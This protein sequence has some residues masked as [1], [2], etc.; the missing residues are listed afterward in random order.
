SRMSIWQFSLQVSRRLLVWA[1]LSIGAGALLAAQKSP[2]LQ[3]V[4]L[5]F[6][7]WGAIDG[8]IG[9]LGARG[10]R[11]RQQA[12]DAHAPQTQTAEARKLRRLLWINTAL[13]VG[14]V[15]GGLQLVRRKGDDDTWRGHGWGIVIQGAFLFFFDLFHALRLQP[16]AFN[17]QPSDD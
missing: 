16:S 1:G 10:S 3:G 13:D 6:A 11:R 5:Q 12:P 15:L 4:G 2:F 17:L 9:L 14:Y 7:G 8:L